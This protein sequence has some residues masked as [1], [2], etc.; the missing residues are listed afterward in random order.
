HVEG[1]ASAALAL[2][3]VWLLNAGLIRFLART[4]GLLFALAAALFIP[5]DS[6]VVGIG[7]LSAAVDW[8]RG[9]RY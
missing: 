8:I 2:A 5:I 1:V 6:L 9:Q 3:L 4:R 7:M